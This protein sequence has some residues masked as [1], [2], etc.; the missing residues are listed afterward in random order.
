MFSWG[1]VPAPV[2]GPVLPANTFLQTKP[3]A[4]SLRRTLV[5]VVVAHPHE[6]GVLAATHQLA[7]AVVEAPH[8]Q[9]VRRPSCVTRV[10][11]TF[12]S[13]GRPSCVTRVFLGWSAELCY[14][15]TRDTDRQTDR[16]TDVLS[17][18]QRARELSFTRTVLYS[19]VIAFS[20]VLPGGAP[21]LCASRVL[22][23]QRK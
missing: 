21:L 15:R 4:H 22:S 17:M 13:D 11:G 12:S 16:Q 10:R 23:A 9:H 7:P 5:K 20:P 19:T 18:G 3:F 8:L 1:P 2:P 6:V 14:R